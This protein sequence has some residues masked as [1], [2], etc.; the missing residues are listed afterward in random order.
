ML[1]QH[2]DPS[3]APPAP[4]TQQGMVAHTRNL[5]ASVGDR[6]ILGDGDGVYGRASLAEWQ[7]LGSVKGFV[8]K[9]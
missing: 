3:L 1:N 6:R 9:S 8:S 4:T 7:A 5:S 2:E